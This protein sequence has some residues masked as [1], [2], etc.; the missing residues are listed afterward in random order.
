MFLATCAI[1]DVEKSWLQDVAPWGR[2]QNAFG[3]RLGAVALDRLDQTHC[4]MWQYTVPENKD[5][6]LRSHTN[7]HKPKIAQQPLVRVTLESC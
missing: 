3:S 7:E 5:P 2:A 6:R 4:H 1:D